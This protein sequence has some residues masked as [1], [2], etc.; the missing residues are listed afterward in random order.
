LESRRGTEREMVPA[1]RGKSITRPIETAQR[2]EYAK[3][4]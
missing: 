1:T 2:H 3:I 4:I